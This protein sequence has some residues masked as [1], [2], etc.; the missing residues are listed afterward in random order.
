MPV[1]RVMIVAAVL[2]LMMSTLVR[3]MVRLVVGGALALPSLRDPFADNVLGVWRAGGVSETTARM[4]VLCLRWGEMVVGLVLIVKG[5]LCAVLRGSLIL[6]MRKRGGPALEVIQPMLM[7]VEM[8][9]LLFII[10]L[11]L[12]RVEVRLVVGGAL[13]LPSLR[14]LFADNALG[15]WGA[16]GVSKTTAR[17]LVLVGMDTMILMVGLVMLMFMV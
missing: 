12:V 2:S 16:G 3:V 11:T 7:T 10:V 13:A 1:L 15:V 9:I 6:V 14:D 17:M 5:E 4:F 8:A